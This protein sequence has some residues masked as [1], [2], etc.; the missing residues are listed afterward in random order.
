MAEL[1]ALNNI[2]D[3]DRV[4]AGQVLQLP[5]ASGFIPVASPTTMLP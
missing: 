2:T 3:P 1:M 5:A 4:N